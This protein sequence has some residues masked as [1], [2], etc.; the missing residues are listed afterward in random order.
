MSI[1]DR[2]SAHATAVYNIIK[3]R[4]EEEKN[5]IAADSGIVSCIHL[6]S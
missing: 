1:I 4:V 5:D 2:S 3:D 6:S